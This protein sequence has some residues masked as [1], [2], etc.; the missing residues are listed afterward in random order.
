MAVKTKRK[1]PRSWEAQELS[2][3]N[4]YWKRP[5]MSQ[6]FQRQLSVRRTSGVQRKSRASSRT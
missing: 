3:I 6:E 4:R 5:L 2:D 1:K